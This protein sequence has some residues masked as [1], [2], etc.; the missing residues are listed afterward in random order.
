MSARIVWLSVANRILLQGAPHQ[1][2]ADR[3]QEVVVS[4]ADSDARRLLHAGAGARV[5]Y[6]RP[7]DWYDAVAGLSAAEVDEVVRR[8]RQSYDVRAVR[9][10][11]LD[12]TL[13][14]CVGLAAA[15][16]SPGARALDG[17]VGQLLARLG[18]QPWAGLS[19]REAFDLYVRSKEQARTEAEAA[20]AALGE[21]GG[22]RF[23]QIADSVTRDFAAVAS[24]A[25]RAGQPDLVATRLDVNVRRVYLVRPFEPDLEAAARRRHN[26]VARW[27][28]GGLVAWPERERD[29]FGHRKLSLVD[30]DPAFLARALAELTPAQIDREVK[31]RL[32]TPPGRDAWLRLVDELWLQAA[33]DARRLAATLRAREPALAAD[34]DR[35]NAEELPRLMGV[36]SHGNGLAPAPAEAGAGDRAAGTPLERARACHAEAIADA[37]FVAGLDEDAGDAAAALAS[38]K[39]RDWL[40]GAKDALGGRTP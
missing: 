27:H 17:Y 15:A 19:A 21:S 14:R 8:R 22:A 5:L 24:T 38:H 26:V 7:R 10:G 20:A 1:V 16:S 4:V 32:A 29:T 36:W 23:R 2:L 37:E 9:H 13:R 31:R 18:E 30:L 33:I 28:D 12:L 34:V 6:W 39:L 3:P 35:A 40:A 11:E 25:T